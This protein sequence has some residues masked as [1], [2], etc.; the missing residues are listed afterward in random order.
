MNELALVIYEP[1]LIK[2]VRDFFVAFLLA[3]LDVVGENTDLREALTLIF[4]L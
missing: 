4:V 1:H 3:G 2:F